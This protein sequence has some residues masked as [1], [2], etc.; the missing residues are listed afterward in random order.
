MM[1]VVFRYK[2]CY[3]TVV[4]SAASCNARGQGF[5]SSWCFFPIL[6]NKVDLLGILSDSES[7]LVIK[8]YRTARVRVNLLGLCSESDRTEKNKMA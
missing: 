6:I 1:F 5:N 3:G 4:Y 2:W 8:Y 7:V